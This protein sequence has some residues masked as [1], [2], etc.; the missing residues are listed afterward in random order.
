MNLKIWRDT[1][2]LSQQ[3]MADFLRVP[4]GTYIKWEHGTRTPGTGMRHW[5]YLLHWLWVL[6]PDI[7]K[8][9]RGGLK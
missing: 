8:S 2:E 1:M 6:H 5:I 7:L 9:Y 3:G 4:R